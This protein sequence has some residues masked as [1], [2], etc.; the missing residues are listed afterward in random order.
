MVGSRLDAIHTPMLLGGVRWIDFDENHRGFVASVYGT[1]Q[2]VPVAVP[3]DQDVPFSGIG[4]DATRF[5]NTKVELWI[6]NIYPASIAD[7]ARYGRAWLSHSPRYVEMP[8][9]LSTFILGGG[10]VSFR[11]RHLEFDGMDTAYVEGWSIPGFSSRMRVYN[12]SERPIDYI[13]PA[14]NDM[15]QV[16]GCMLSRGSICG[17]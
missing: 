1:L 10:W 7:P 11:V 4:L 2:A 8:E 14:D 5:G 12:R 15:L 16:G 9:G 13:N 6:R 17:P 3:T